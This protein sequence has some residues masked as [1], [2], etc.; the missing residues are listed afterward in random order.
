MTLLFDDQQRFLAGGVLLWRLI[1]FAARLTSA[2]ALIG[3]TSAHAQNVSAASP[4]AG[5]TDFAG[6]YAQVFVPNVTPQEA[7]RNPP[8]FGSPTPKMHLDLDRR[9]DDHGAVQRYPFAGYSG[10]GAVVPNYGSGQSDTSNASLCAP[11]LKKYQVTKVSKWQKRYN[12]CMHGN[13]NG[14]DQL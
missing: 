11:L 1:G 2:L 14:L 5:V 13:F 3:I 10:G 12:G 9:L 8:Q 7:L 4:R 6:Q